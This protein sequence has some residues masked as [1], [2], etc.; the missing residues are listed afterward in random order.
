MAITVRSRKSLDHFPASRA[1]VCV[2]THTHT[3]TTR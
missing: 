1:R 3:H 2:Y